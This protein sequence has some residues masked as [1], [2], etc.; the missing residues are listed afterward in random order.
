M[1]ACEEGVS[2]LDVASRWICDTGAARD[3]VSMKMAK[4]HARVFSDTKPVQ[5]ATAN[6]SYQADK[7]LAMDTP[8][9]GSVGAKAYVMNDSPSAFSVGRRCVKNGYSFV[10]I[11]DK[12][13]AL[14]CQRM[15]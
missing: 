10:W 9:L 4:H 15:E 5:F 13:P 11:K 1:P 6:G 3:L 2:A 8:G 14:S 7:V 12:S